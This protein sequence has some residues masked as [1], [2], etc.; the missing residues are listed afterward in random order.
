MWKEIQSFLDEDRPWW[1][2]P[3]SGFGAAIVAGSLYRLIMSPSA[4]KRAGDRVPITERGMPIAYVEQ[5]GPA[6]V[7]NKR[8]MFDSDVYGLTA[9]TF[10]HNEREATGDDVQ[11]A[12]FE[13]AIPNLQAMYER[14]GEGAD[15]ARILAVKA[16]AAR[17]L[18]PSRRQRFNVQI[19]EAFQQRDRAER[20]Q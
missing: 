20:S 19:N 2:W 11:L 10:L 12:M 17:V 14:Q 5:V 9:L 7:A 6:P 16:A 3:L 15:R 18:D 4:P 8:H 13:G 1:A